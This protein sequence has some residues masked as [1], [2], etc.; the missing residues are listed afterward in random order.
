MK[1]IKRDRAKF[2]KNVY[3]LKSN[4]VPIIGIGAAA[5]GNT[6]LNFYNLDSTVLD[7]VTDASDHK[8]GKYTP[9]TR[10]KITSDNILS[11]YNKISAMVLS[12]NISDIIKEKLKSIN[13]NIDFLE[14]NK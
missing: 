8:I 9:L 2:L 5:K 3:H 1:E 10:I 12:W 6:F 7:Y 4:G 11:N 14:P 13:Q